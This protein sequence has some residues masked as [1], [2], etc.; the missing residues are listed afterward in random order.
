ML[1]ASDSFQNHPY[2]YFYPVVA[3]TYPGEQQPLIVTLDDWC[4]P[5]MIRPG[6]DRRMQIPNV[7]ERA[8]EDWIVE[9]CIGK[10]RAR[11][12]RRH[13]AQRWVRA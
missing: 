1:E 2:P 3:A 13:E 7:L 4:M 8:F 6:D 10:N 9:S 12:K 11:G 5:R